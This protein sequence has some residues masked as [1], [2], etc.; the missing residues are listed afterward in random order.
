MNL[1]E[2]L[3]RE[4]A[5]VTELR[6]QYAELVGMPG[7]NV[8]PVMFLIDHAL[9][10]AKLAAGSPDIEGQMAAVFDLEGFTS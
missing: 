3:A 9:E 5:R 1:P 2:K 7:G 8:R 4:I 6:G 10:Q